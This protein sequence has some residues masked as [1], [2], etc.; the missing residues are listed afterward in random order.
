MQTNRLAQL[1]ALVLIAG[2]LHAQIGGNNTYEF[3]NLPPSARVAAL[4]G[5]LITVVDDDEALAVQNPA[6]L[7]PAMHGHI[8]FQ[9]AIWFARTNH[10]Y[11]G[12][13]HHVDKW[14]TTMHGGV[15]FINYGKFIRADESGEQLGDFKANDFAV[16][17]GAGR[18]LSDRTSVGANLKFIGSRLDS[19]HSYGAALDLAGTYNDTAKDVTFTLAI[20]NLGVQFSTY[21]GKREFLPNDIQIGISKK[22]PYLP[23]RLSVIAHTLQRWSIRYDDPNAPQ[24]SSLLGGSEPAKD[25]PVGDFFDNFFRHFIFSGEFLLGKKENFRIRFA[26]NHQ[27]RGELSVSNLRSLAGISGGIGIKIKQFRFDYGWS[28]YHIGGSTHT[29]GISTSI[30]AFK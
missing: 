13:A 28:S 16:Y 12:Y 14:K 9:D 26:Y 19:Y 25:K 3:L 15:Q 20:R 5:N 30:G 23:L 6:A 7:N 2:S 4:G 21:S 11:A 29:I 22:L 27:R 10:M 8:T 1:F 17:V 18:M 24:E